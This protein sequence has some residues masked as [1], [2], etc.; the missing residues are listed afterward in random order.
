[1]CFINIFHMYCSITNCCTALFVR[2]IYLF[3]ES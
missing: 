3:T 2:N 1:M